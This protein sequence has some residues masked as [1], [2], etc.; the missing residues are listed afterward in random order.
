M[1]PRPNRL[2]PVR[3]ILLMGPGGKLIFYRSS[4][5]K[6]LLGIKLE[7]E[8]VWLSQ[9]QMA[10]LFGKDADTIGLQIRNAFKEKEFDEQETSEE[11]SVVQK[12]G[13]RSVRRVVHFYTHLLGQPSSEAL[14]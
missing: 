4:D 7:K 11:S 6:V 2:V 3:G 10:L 13:R 5:G 12:E 9:K 8:T 1:S 14:S